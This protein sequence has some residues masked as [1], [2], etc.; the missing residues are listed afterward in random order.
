MDS[1]NSGSLQ[2]SSG[3]DD[4]YD[5][6]T[7]PTTGAA[8][9]VHAPPPPPPPSSSS[10]LFDTLTYFESSF[11]RSP[12]PPP[13]SNTTNPFLN[14]ESPWPRHL[15]PPFN[16][17]C[18]TDI[19]GLITPSAS[20]STAAA[21]TTPVQP[22]DPPPRVSKKRSRASRRAPTTVL[23]TDTTNFRAM[24]QEFTGIPTAPFS[25]ATSSSPFPRSR[26]PRYQDSPYLLRPFAHKV[27]HAI[28]AT[29]PPF[30]SSSSTTNNA[31]VTASSSSTNQLAHDHHLSTV[32]MQNQVLNFQ[33]LLQPPISTNNLPSFMTNKSQINY[34]T[35][36]SDQIG[37]VSANLSG[38]LSSLVG[39]AEG[40][41][42]GGCSEFHPEKGSDGGRPPRSEGMVDSWICS[43]E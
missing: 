9:S 19:T 25:A 13:S 38:N 18:T 34:G 32:S 3:G 23:T 15:R 26:L 10:S 28:A 21:T 12:P 2:S 29:F 22:P 4:D 1:G 41:H 30:P 42:S 16:P 37:Q 33:S 39:S 7:G 5:Y 24:V 8:T 14:L 36:V 40:M 31:T 43:S 27:P 20:S 6:T 11:P 17:N 35:H